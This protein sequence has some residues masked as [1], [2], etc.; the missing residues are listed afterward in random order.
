MSEI[1]IS[2]SDLQLNILKLCDV[3]S[4]SFKNQE[5]ILQGSGSSFLQWQLETSINSE[6]IMIKPT[7]RRKLFHIF[8][9][10]GLKVQSVLFYG[11]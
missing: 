9:D 6:A 4:L 11:F 1:E 10:S 2:I 5:T 8:S 7:L 3:I